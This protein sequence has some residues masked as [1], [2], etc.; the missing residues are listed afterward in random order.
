[1]AL[2]NL[3]A[4]KIKAVERTVHHRG[5]AVINSVP[6]D[7][8]LIS[9]EAA[10]HHLRRTSRRST[11][12]NARCAVCGVFSMRIAALLHHAALNDIDGCRVMLNRQPEPAPD[13]STVLQWLRPT[14][15]RNV[16]FF[17]FGS[18]LPDVFCLGERRL[19]NGQCR[20]GQ[21]TDKT[22]FPHG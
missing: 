22:D 20:D 4:L 12:R 21:H 15:R 3:N 19:K 16:F 6:Q 7:Q 9:A 18:R 17:R 2:E 11:G 10:H 1:M 14:V 5:R 8:N 13:N